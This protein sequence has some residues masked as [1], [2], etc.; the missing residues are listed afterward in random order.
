MKKYIYLVA[1]LIH[2]DISA[3]EL[4]YECDCKYA[5]IFV[6]DP[7]EGVENT[8]EDPNCEMLYEGNAETENFIINFED[9]YV[10]NEEYSEMKAE[11]EKIND[12]QYHAYIS[13]EQ[14]REMFEKEKESQSVSEEMSD[15]AKGMIE[16]LGGMLDFS[17]IEQKTSFEILIDGR[18]QQDNEISIEMNFA[19]MFK[20]LDM[21]MDDDFANIEK[22]VTKISSYS[23][24]EEKS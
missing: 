4:K 17:S 16:M 9:K 14:F 23:M 1:F 19:E 13:N 24:C 11:I 18:I 22:F 6:S 12:A 20:G 7:I 21:P 10:Y 15:F 5:E 3:E 2:L 8:Q